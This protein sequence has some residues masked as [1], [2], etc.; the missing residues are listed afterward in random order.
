M[1]ARGLLL[2]LVVGLAASALRPAPGGAQETRVVVVVGLAGTPEYREEF[3]MWASEL[4]A[5]L[6]GKRGVAPTSITV[7][8]ESPDVAPGIVG[9]RSTRDGILAALAA[10]ARAAGPQDRILVVLIGHGTSQGEEGRLNIPGPDLSGADLALALSPFSTQTVAVVHTGSAGGGFVAP[11]SGPR[12]IVLS[13]TR[14][15][16]ERNATEFARWFVEALSGDGS[17]LDKDGAVSLLEAFVYARSEVARHYAEQKELLTEHAVLDDDG[18]GQGSP[19]P[20]AQAGDGPRADAFR[21]GAAA[22]RAAPATADP[23]LARLYGERRAI[24]ERIDALRGSRG[25]MTAEQYDQALE[26]LLVELALKNRE[27]RAREGGGA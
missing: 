3:G 12:R 19:D 22:V 13:A 21:F 27:I 9:G 16:R 2:A 6:T 20:G 17:D 11:L 1:S 26:A 24:Q 25:T 23:V 18:D 10:T 4:H 8:A 14:T 5:A 15:A 7:L